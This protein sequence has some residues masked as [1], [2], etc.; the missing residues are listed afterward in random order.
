NGENEADHI[1]IVVWKKAAANVGQYINKGSNVAVSGR[2]QSRTYQDKDEKT[3]FVTEVVSNGV[4]FLETKNSQGNQRKD[5][6]QTD[7]NSPF[8]SGQEMPDIDDDQLPF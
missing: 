1:K 2:L 3:V 4:E 8:T 5:N 6:K 7:I